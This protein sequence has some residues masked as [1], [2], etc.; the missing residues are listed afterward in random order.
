MAKDAP[1]V[2]DEQAK[3]GA[4]SSRNVFIFAAIGSAVGLGNI[5]RFP[6]VAYENGG[7]A[8]VIP[9]LIALLTA[10]IPFLFLDYAIGH[11]YRGSAPLSFAR[12]RRGAEGLGW[13]QVGICFVIAVY[14]AAVI[15]WALR[16]TVF[17]VDKAWGNDPEGFFLGDFLQVSEPGVTLEIVPGVLVPMLLVWLAVIAIMVAGRAEGD[18]RHLG[19]LHPG[20]GDRLRRAGRPGALPARRRRGAQRLLHPRLGGADRAGRVGR[21]LR[22]DLLLALHRLRHHDHLRLLRAPRH[23]HDR[24]RPGGRLR[25]LQLR[26]ARRHRRLR[27]AGLHGPGPGGRGRRRRERRDRAG[28]HRLPGDHQRGAVGGVHR[29]LL[30]RLPGAGRAHLAGLGD[31]GGDLRGPRQVRDGPGGRRLR[32]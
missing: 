22:P 2:T 8:F 1:Q 32:R 20:A 7:G 23:R 11:R 5:W 15:A 24:L 27:R 6:Y 25:Q 9:Y 29:R 4:F 17:S 3:R 19:R 30:L 12:L 13:W 16:Y 31:R 14:Y 18:R 26:A 10:G 21:G 28:V